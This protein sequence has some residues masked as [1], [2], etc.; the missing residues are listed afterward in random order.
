MPAAVAPSPTTLADVVTALGDIPLHRVLW[1]PRPG[2]ATES[3][4]LRAAAGE[5]KL[6][7]ELVDRILVLKGI[8]RDDLTAY[9]PAVVT[10]ADVIDRLGGIPLDRIVWTPFPGTAT[11]ADAVALI[12]GDPK[13]LVELV[14]DI[15]VEKPMGFREGLLAG[16]LITCLNNFVV[17]RRLGRVGAPDTIV[18]LLGR[19]VRLPDVSY[20]PFAVLAAAGGSRTRVGTVAPAI[21]CEILSDS[22]T[23]AE[24]ERKRREYFAAGSSLVWIV[25]PRNETVDVFTTAS[26]GTTL[27]VADTLDGVTVLLGFQLPVAELFGYLDEPTSEAAPSESQS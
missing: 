8:R 11:E 21:A 26:A 12:E 22:N 4:A 6:R 9:A 24:I 20:Y 15:L 19:Q 14:D 25:D 27:T 16:W 7:A 18:R 2:T 13:R 3:D 10:L 17:P 1:N 23:R 5:P